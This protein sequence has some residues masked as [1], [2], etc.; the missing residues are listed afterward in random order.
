MSIAIENELK[1]DGGVPSLKLKVPPN[2]C[3]PSNAKIRIK[4]NSSSNK[5]MIDLI[6]LSNDIT[7]LRSEDQYLKDNKM[8]AK[9][10]IFLNTFNM[11]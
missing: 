7:R 11:H 8:S 6:E 4:R 3:I 2:S 10:I 9:Y 1:F 5:D